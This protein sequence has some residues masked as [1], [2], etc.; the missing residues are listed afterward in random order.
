MKILLK[1]NI[2]VTY[3]GFDLEKDKA[4]EKAAGVP[5]D[6]SG[7]CLLDCERDIS[8]T[9]SSVGEAKA[10]SERIKAAVPGTKVTP[11]KQ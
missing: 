1:P 3:E 7:Y 4:I 6:G 9:F 8:F 5:R 2:S 11:K 10:A